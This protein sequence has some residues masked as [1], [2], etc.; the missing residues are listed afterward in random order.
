MNDARLL[1]AAEQVDADLLAAL[2]RHG[3]TLIQTLADAGHYQ[4]VE[5]A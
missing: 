1:A 2:T 4:I 3:R 5:D